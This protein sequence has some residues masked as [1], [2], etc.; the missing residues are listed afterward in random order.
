MNLYNIYT[1]G[2]LVK[3][4]RDKLD[5]SKFGLQ[6]ERQFPLV[7]EEHVRKAIQLFNKCPESKREELA[8][9]IF[10][11]AQEFNV[12]ISKSSSLFK[13]LGEKEQ[14]LVL[15]DKQNLNEELIFMDFLNF[16]QIPITKENIDKYYY[17]CPDLLTLN[18]NE[19]GLILIDKE[20]QVVGYIQGNL[21]TGFI[22]KIFVNPYY[23]EQG[24]GSNLLSHMSTNFTK[25]RV[26]S[27]NTDTINFFKKN[28]FKE[29]NHTSIY[30]LMELASVAGV[31]NTAELVQPTI[32]NNNYSSMFDYD[33]FFEAEESIFTDNSL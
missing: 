20:S 18:G 15:N 11:A 24:I 32:R 33:E 14:K 17:S 30:T 19:E 28:G 16:Y 9:R 22:E 7:D 8:N 21:E 12:K 25:A 4:E 1:E 2:E 29:I 5:S 10:S 23:R 13:Y 27:E 3:A 6:K 26:L 31:A